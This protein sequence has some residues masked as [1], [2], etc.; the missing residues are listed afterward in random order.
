MP[1]WCKMVSMAQLV[2]PAPVGAQMS[3][4]S[5]ENSAVSQIL[6][7]MRLRDFMPLNAG[8]AHSGRL[9]ISLSCSPVVIELCCTGNRCIASVDHHCAWMSH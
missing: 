6:D 5:A 7:W 3:M 8:W 2:L 1:I 4:F 9:V